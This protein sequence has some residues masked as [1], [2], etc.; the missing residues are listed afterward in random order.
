MNY[1]R[2]LRDMM[3][4]G[5]LTQAELAKLLKVT[6]PTVSRWL[7]G[8]ATPELEQHQRIVA[9]GRKLGLIAADGAEVD[10][11]PERPNEIGPPTVKV[12]GYVGAG[13]EAHF[14]NVAQGDLD[15]VP[16]PEGATA[17]TVAVE[18]RGDSLGAL[19]DRWLVF[20]D[21]VRR[22]ITPDLVGKLCVVGLA[23]DRVLVKKVRRG[24]AAG[25][26]TLISE[27]E[28]PIRDV[29]I[30]WAAQVKNMVPR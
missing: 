26:Y 5:G 30:E 13:A 9:Q 10:P 4:A 12:K 27:R 19:F 14:Y 16:A 24:S 25:L 1:Q 11:H 21:E 3:K 17:D 20:Y 28:E 18:I 6:Q 7:S 23:D 15:D 22:P 29:E 2:V 8:G